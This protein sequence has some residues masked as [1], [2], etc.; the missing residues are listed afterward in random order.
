MSAQSSQQDLFD[1]LQ[2]IPLLRRDATGTGD[3]TGR[4]YFNAGDVDLDSYDR[5]VLCM[6]MGKDGIACWL[7]LLDQDVDPSKVEFWH[8]RV[9]GNEGSQL[10]DWV[11]IDEYAR[12]FAATYNIPLYFSWLEG[13][14]EG[15]LLKDN[16]YSRPHHIE[17]PDGLMVLERDKKR[18]KPGTRLRFPQQSADLNTR[19]CSSAVKIDVARRALNNQPRFNGART[20]FITGE[21]REESSN[22]ARYNQLEAH[23]CDR[24]NG[25]LARHVDHYRPIL[26]WREDQVWDA[27][28]RHRV[29][30]PVPYRLGWSRSSCQTCIYSDARIWA[31]LEAYF[32]NRVVPIALY[33]DRFGTTISRDRKTVRQRI[34]EARPFDIADVEALEQSRSREYTLP[35]LLPEGEK[36]IL[37]AGAYGKNGCGAN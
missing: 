6:S 30:A 4:A 13:G 25:R 28:E 7:H 35:V 17:T 9:D 19:W 18:A 37:P 29:I 22:R 36:W 2:V 27:L 31:T 23:F 11:F 3:V 21:R 1:D 14:F 34:S 26:N 33:E 12:L 16:A 20:L 24:S 8:H 32:P 10:M 5:I 15:E